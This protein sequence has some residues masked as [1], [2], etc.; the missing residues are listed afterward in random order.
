[1]EDQKSFD[2]NDR[3]G[4]DFFCL[5]ISKKEENKKNLSVLGMPFI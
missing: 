2:N 5:Q 1:M 3:V 4:P